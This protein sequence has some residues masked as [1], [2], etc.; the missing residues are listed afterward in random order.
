M[1]KIS[2]LMS[3]YNDAGYLR[4]AI[5]SIL[6]QTFT[7]FEFIIFDDAST[8]HTWETLSEYAQKDQRIRLIKNEQNLG[9]TKSLNKGI[10]LAQGDYIARQDSDDVALPHRFEKQSAVL[11]DRPEIVLVSCALELIDP[12]GNW[13]E[14]KLQNLTNPLVIRW[15]L[16]FYNCIAGHSQV[17]FRRETAAKLGGYDETRRYSQDYELWCR[18]A[19]Q[20]DIVILPEVL[21]KQRMHS[22]SVSI[23]KRSQQQ[24]LSLDQAQKNIKALIGKALPHE[25]LT[26]LQGFY[27]IPL[28]WF[29][30]PNVRMPTRQAA[31]LQQNL[32]TIYSRFIQAQGSS[33]KALIAAQEIRRLTSQQYLCWMEHL[34]FRANPRLKL[35]TLAY[36]LHWSPQEIWQYFWRGEWRTPQARSKQICTHKRSSPSLETY[37]N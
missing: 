23:Q 14:T 20:G 11:A 34:S 13:L 19:Q 8:D 15:L 18:L 7:D 4:E 30:F 28:Y 12:E 25:L 3:V 36:A 2:V 22:Q 31:T 35:Q 32:T 24:A 6:S 17:M 29:F 16:L 21:H 26:D 27:L 1:V 10:N 37:A 9:L 5:E 33:E